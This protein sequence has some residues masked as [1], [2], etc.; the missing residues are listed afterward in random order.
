V[1]VQVLEVSLIKGGH[2]QRQEELHLPAD[3]WVLE[4]LRVQVMEILRPLLLLEG[5]QRQACFVLQVIRT[6]VK[7]KVLPMSI[8]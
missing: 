5:G 4:L 7:W 6:A 1:R 3:D 8:G 2:A